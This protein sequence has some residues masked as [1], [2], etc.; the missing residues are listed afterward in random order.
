MTKEVAKI[1][2]T[3]M[4]TAQ[5]ASLSPLVQMAM[6]KDF[7]VDKM[8]KLLAVQKDWEANEAR[9]AFCVAMAACQKEMPMIVKTAENNQTHSLYARHEM[10]CKLIKPVYTRHGFSLSFSEGVAKID[11]EIRTL[12]DVDHSQGFSKNYYMDLPR[13]DKG[14]QGKANKTP[15]HGKAST[16]SYGRRYLTMMIFDLATYD[17]NDAQTRP[18]EPIPPISQDQLA[19]INDLIKT[20]RDADIP[21]DDAKFLQRCKAESIETLPSINYTGAINLLWE[22]LK[23]G[24]KN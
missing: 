15:I 9:K 8:D 11:S 3:N 12:C 7:D 1:K 4:E 6:D 22:K 2:N 20:I 24:G 18:A 10:I 23:Q 17:D 21:F 16:F 5:P 14:M 13:D 19:E